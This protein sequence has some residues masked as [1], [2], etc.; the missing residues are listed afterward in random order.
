MTDE[1]ELTFRNR[2]LAFCDL[3]DKCARRRVR[4]DF[5]KGEMQI[6]YP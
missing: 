1:S 4:L 5:Q 2:D 6:R 3:F